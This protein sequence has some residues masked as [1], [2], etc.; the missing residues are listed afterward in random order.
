MDFIVKDGVIIR[1]AEDEK[2]SKKKKGDGINSAIGLLQELRN[3]Q[4]K[5]EACI[6]SQ[7]I[8]ENKSKI[9]EHAQSLDAMYK[10][11]IEIASNGVRSMGQKPTPEAM[12]SDPSPA[13]ATNSDV[14]TPDLPSTPSVP[15][16][17]KIG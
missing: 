17:S 16:A 2:G 3:F 15:A 8:A 11:L 10:A 6:E 5:V 4:E 14:K 1:T 7:D 13:P 12:E 9:Q